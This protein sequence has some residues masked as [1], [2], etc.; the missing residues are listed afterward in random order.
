MDTDKKVTLRGIIGTLVIYLV[1]A[2]IFFYAANDRIYYTEYNK[3]VV[4]HDGYT[5]EL[6]HGS[7]LTQKIK[8]DFEYVYN[9]CIGV[10]TFGRINE[11]NIVVLLEDL[12]GNVI[13]EKDFEVSEIEDNSDLVLVCNN[14]IEKG[15]YVL[16]IIAEG[17]S[18]GKAI[19]AYYNSQ[20]VTWGNGYTFNEESE[21]GSLLL[22]IK[23]GKTREYG[24]LYWP[25]VIVFAFILMAHL[26]NTSNIERKGKSNYTLRTISILSKYRFL[27]KQLVSRDFKTKYKRSALGICWSLL[28][29]LMI[30]AVQY[31]VFST[32]FRSNIENYPVYLLSGS[33][34]FTFF[35]DSVGAGLTAI[36]GNS[37]L[38]TKVYVPKYIYPVSKVLSTAI[39]LI[40]SIIPL[41]VVVL[42]TG[43]SITKAYLLIPYVFLCILIFCIGM[44]FLLSSS[45]VFF[46]DTQFLWSVAS[47]LWMYATPMFYPASIIP[48]HMN[49]ILWGNPMYHYISFF[50]TI[51]MD[52][53]S[54]NLLSYV[55]C[56][57]FSILFLV[58]GIYVYKKTQ[59]KFVLYI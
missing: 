23:G 45:M 18:Q 28:Y 1:C 40:L 38:I 30:M 41:M 53:V 15:E 13:K 56:M 49:F 43:E 50:R 17:A 57:L 6:V 51:L 34:L 24:G 35:T 19:T 26:V 7:M 20:D 29:P 5:K 10:A 47:M 22:K 33:V 9:I 46:R 59:N 21:I 55:Y 39:N 12:N 54:P 4:E 2:G 31:V 27:I 37:S 32:I 44:S 58:A 52:G 14:P 48:Q 3:G 36:V 16:K 11:G 42:I 8:L 25:I